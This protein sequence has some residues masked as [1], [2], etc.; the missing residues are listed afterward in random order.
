MGQSE[1][2]QMKGFGQYSLKVQFVPLSPEIVK[3]VTSYL[4]YQFS[5]SF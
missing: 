3:L 2:I 1:I 5:R 4:I